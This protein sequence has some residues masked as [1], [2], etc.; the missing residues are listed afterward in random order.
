[1]VIITRNNI[2]ALRAGD[3]KSTYWLTE[4]DLHDNQIVAIH[5]DTFQGL[6]RL[7]RYTK[8]AGS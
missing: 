7:E 4:L 6:K 2:T 8:L 3:F 1:M 5:V